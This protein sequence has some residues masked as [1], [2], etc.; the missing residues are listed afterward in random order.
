MYRFAFI[1]NPNSAKNNADNFLRELRSR[2]SDPLYHISHSVHSTNDFILEHFEDVDVF[3][4][5]GGDGTISSVASAL[6]NTKKLLAILPAGSGNGFSREMKFSKD[7]GSLLTKI[8]NGKFIEVDTFTV[9][10]RF[11]VNVSGTGFDG[12]VIQ[13]FE[14]TSRGFGNY[15]R[16]SVAKYRTYEPVN[17]RFEE[18][19]SKYDGQYLMV[20]VANT[21]QFGNNAFIAPQASHSDGLLEIALVKKFPFAHAPLFAYRMFTKKLI[22]NQYISYLS[23]PEI[24]FEA[25]TEVWHLDGEGVNIKSPVHIK[26]LPKSLK[27]LV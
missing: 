11:S 2:V 12:A 27:I 7:L 22:P 6:I 5:V 26:I 8:L 9:N 3:V 10:G 25:D 4:A 19:Y 23:V 16:T 1:I 13:A 21:R 20:N 14:K 15:I 24:R 17:V 18:K